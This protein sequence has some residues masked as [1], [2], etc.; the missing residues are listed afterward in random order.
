MCPT[1]RPLSVSSW[2]GMSKYYCCSGICFMACLNGHWS[3]LSRSFVRIHS[4]NHDSIASEAERTRFCMDKSMARKGWP[5]T[6]FQCKSKMPAACN[7]P[8][9]LYLST[10]KKQKTWFCSV[11][12]LSIV[13]K[14]HLLASLIYWDRYIKIEELRKLMALGQTKKIIGG[15]LE[16]YH[17]EWKEAKTTKPCSALF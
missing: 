12:L 14:T 7:I 4:H 9:D 2:T 10:R 8:S 6:I 3:D 15:W 17:E 13:K 5:T 11:S 1:S 16:N